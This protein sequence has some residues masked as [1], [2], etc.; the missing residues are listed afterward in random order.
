MRGGGSAW[1]AAACRRCVGRAGMK[2]G[3][4]AGRRGGRIPPEPPVFPSAR[5]ASTLSGPGGTRP[6]ASDGGT[7]STASLG[8]GGTGPSNASVAAAFM[9]LDLPHRA[10]CPHQCQGAKAPSRKVQQALAG[11]T[12]PTRLGGRGSFGGLS[13]CVFAALRLCV[14]LPGLGEAVGPA[15]EE[16]KMVEEGAQRQARQLE[17]VPG[18]VGTPTVRRRTSWCLRYRG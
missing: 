14:E 16:I 2:L 8:P 5:A 12:P 3:L 10:G 13:P 11:L 1:T 17:L 7:P 4:P 15:P 9:P 6:T 18:R